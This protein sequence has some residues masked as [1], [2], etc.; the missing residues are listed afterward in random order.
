[1]EYSIIS[2]INH[3][4]KLPMSEAL[5]LCTYYL[6]VDDIREMTNVELEAL[7]NL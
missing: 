6:L 5:T 4:L 3:D 7:R 2:H 1:M